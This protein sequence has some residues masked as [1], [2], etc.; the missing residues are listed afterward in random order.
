MLH[1]VQRMPVQ[2]LLTDLVLPSMDGI[3]LLARVHEINAQIAGI[4]MTG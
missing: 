1:V 4:V 3:E 2:V